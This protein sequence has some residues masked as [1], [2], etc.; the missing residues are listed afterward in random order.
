VKGVYNSIE[1]THHHEKEFPSDRENEGYCSQGESITLHGEYRH[2]FT[3]GMM[4]F[5]VGDDFETRDD[6]ISCKTSIIMEDVP[7]KGKSK[8]GTWR[9]RE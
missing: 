1:S 8:K 3:L 4:I 2:H 9:L 6:V 7:E 5:T